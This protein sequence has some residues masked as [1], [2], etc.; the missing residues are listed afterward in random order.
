ML[1]DL[2]F[3]DYVARRYK[4]EIAEELSANYTNRLD[5]FKIELLNAY[6]RDPGIRRNG[7]NSLALL[8]IGH[9]YEFQTMAIQPID[10]VLGVM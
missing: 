2:P 7:D 6:N 3:L 8:H 1:L 10:D 4:G 5:R 9:E